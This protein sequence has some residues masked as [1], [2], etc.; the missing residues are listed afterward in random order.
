VQ[1]ECQGQHVSV[2][3]RMRDLARNFRRDRE[4]LEGG[5]A[6]PVAATPRGPPAPCGA[7][8]PPSDGRAGPDSPH[9]TAPKDCSQAECGGRR[10]GSGVAG[11][12]CERGR[13][14]AGE[15]RPAPEE[16][17]RRIMPGRRASMT[18]GRDGQWRH[19]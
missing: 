18:T 19:T 14:P 3:S 12:S 4:R 15:V 16:T 17:A 9:W 11:R 6:I 10:R 1:G 8:L 5:Q 2:L 7:S 13:W